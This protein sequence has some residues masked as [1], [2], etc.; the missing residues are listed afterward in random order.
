MKKREREEREKKK[1]LVGNLMQL[2]A[3]SFKK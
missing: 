3:I 2:R 1:N